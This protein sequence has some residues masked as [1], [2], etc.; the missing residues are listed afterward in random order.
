[1]LATNELY[2]ARRYAGASNKFDVG[3]EF[4]QYS[5]I[6]ELWSSG[7]CLEL[8]NAS[9]RSGEGKSLGL[10]DNIL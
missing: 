10:T 1:M 2:A 9:T 3:D 5:S 7:A 6:T 8:Q 4:T